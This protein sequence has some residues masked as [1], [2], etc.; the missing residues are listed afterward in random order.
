MF[1]ITIDKYGPS[2]PV[3]VL[4]TNFLLLVNTARIIIWPLKADLVDISTYVIPK[5]SVMEWLLYRLGQ[6]LCEF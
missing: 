3:Y 2:T 5:S 1:S 4:E 6:K